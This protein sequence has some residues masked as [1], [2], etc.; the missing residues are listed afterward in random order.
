MQRGA[1]CPLCPCS[2][3]VQE[4]SCSAAKTEKL[5]HLRQSMGLINFKSML[6]SV[7]VSQKTSLV[8][9]PLCA[10]SSLCTPWRHDADVGYDA[11]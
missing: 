11:T 4:R 9:R 7:T 5:V 6:T 2:P 10:V 8:S 1:E 3:T